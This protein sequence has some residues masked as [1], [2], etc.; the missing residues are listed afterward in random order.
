MQKGSISPKNEC[1]F[2]LVEL[3][4]AVAI[5]SIV[6]I[7]LVQL[8]QSTNK[9]YTVQDKIATMQQDIRAALN[10]ISRDIRMAGLNRAE[11]SCSGFNSTSNSTLLYVKSDFDLD[12]YC[13]QTRFN[14]SRC[15]Q[16]NKNGEKSLWSGSSTGDLQRLVGNADKED[17]VVDSVNIEYKNDD[18][19]PVDPATNSESVRLV[20]IEVCGKISGSFEEDFDDT[21]CF[22]KTVKCRNMG[23]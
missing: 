8:F 3:M 12:G 10:M 19:N 6:L 15:Y 16:Y 11:A 23:I 1:G 17:L 21:Y 13:N 7:S 4:V 14:E 20:E 2:T 18:G 9:M 5:S 22:S